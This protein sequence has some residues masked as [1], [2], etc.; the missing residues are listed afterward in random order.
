[1]LGSWPILRSAVE[2]GMLV[3]PFTEGVTTDIGYDL[4]ATAETL[5]RPEVASFMDWILTEARQ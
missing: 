1:M 2:G 4:V 3:R 5:A